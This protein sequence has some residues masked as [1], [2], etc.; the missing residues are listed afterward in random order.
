MPQKTPPYQDREQLTAVVANQAGEIF[1]LDGYSAVGMSGQTMTPLSAGQT[2]NI[3]H[4]S[5]FMYL[6]DRFPIL[7]NQRTGKIETLAEN[8]YAPGESI[9]QT[10]PIMPAAT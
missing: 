3:P 8:P 9:F 5:E 6:P 7:F 2:I 10:A 1:D 4:G